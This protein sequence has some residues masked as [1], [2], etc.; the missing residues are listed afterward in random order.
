L[1]G[2]L[3]RQTGAIQFQYTEIIVKYY[4]LR[5]ASTLAFFLHNKC[6]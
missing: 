6:P 1:P 2:A 3:P 5:P 4:F